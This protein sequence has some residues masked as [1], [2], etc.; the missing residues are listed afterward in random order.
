M[1]PKQKKTTPT[2]GDDFRKFFLRG[3]AILLPSLVTL[4]LVFWAY[5]FLLKNIAGPINAGVRQGII[6][7][8][9]ELLSDEHMESYQWYFVTPEE[10][11]EERASRRHRDVSDG[12]LMSA[13]RAAS[14]RELWSAKWYLTAIGFV[15]A[16]IL[17][18][19]AGILVGNYLGRRAYQ[20]IEGWFVRLPV[21]K[22]VYPNVKQVT[23]FLIP[24]DNGKE[25]KQKLPSDGR[26]VLVEYPRKG[27]WTV[28]LLT[29]D[30][31][32]AIEK[33]AQA[34]CVTVFIPSSPTPF[35]GYTIT[36]PAD[37]VHELPISFDEAI[38]FVVSGGVLVPPREETNH[39]TRLA[40][41]LLSDGDAGG[42]NDP[43]E[44]QSPA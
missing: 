3:L 43:R 31:M 44:S 38:R 34:R 36:V 17:V 4:A 11:A 18:Y 39:A 28:G 29:G 20:R 7:L 26:V 15:V 12:T 6:T 25:K 23:E 19:L 21:I 37:E 13:I 32:A 35:T 27:I 9:P 10:L 33:I 2:F 16:I 14:L 24:G 40:E 42:D 8:G 41:G 30:T 22:Q 5:D 1:T